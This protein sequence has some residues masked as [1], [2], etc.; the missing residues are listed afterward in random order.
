MNHARPAT[1]A[2]IFTD[3]IDRANKRETIRDERDALAAAALGEPGNI[4]DKMPPITSA[5]LANVLGVTPEKLLAVAEGR[6]TLAHEHMDALVTLTGDPSLRGKL[7]SA[8]N[9]EGQTKIQVGDYK[10]AKRK[11]ALS[12]ARAHE[13][14][15][16]EVYDELADLLGKADLAAREAA[17]VAEAR[18]R[19]PI[20]R[21][22]KQKEPQA[23]PAPSSSEPS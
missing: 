2:S 5:K 9:A 1:H 16:D 14:V 23:V 17:E 10:G 7:L 3:A 6:D 8:R 13:G 21:P 18:K 12:L 20:I 15:D 19:N 11:L 22:K 4:G